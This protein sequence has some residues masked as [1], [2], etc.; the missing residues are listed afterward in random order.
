MSVNESASRRDGEAARTSD[1]LVARRGIARVVPAR[2]AALPT[3]R[4][5]GF[6]LLALV[7]VFGLSAC[8]LGIDESPYSSI[9]P[10]TETASDIQ[11]LYKTLFYM[12]AV[13]FVLVQFLVLYTALRY[14][15]K[16]R[17]VSRPA[18]VH[19]NSRLEITWT[20]IPAVV[21]LIILVPTISILYS[22]DAD[23]ED[24]ENAMIVQVY[25]KQ[26]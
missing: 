1:Q 10:A 13:V 4:L 9:D 5:C 14:R 22:M 25:G 15:R 19:G 23:A 18:Q 24:E 8:S 2:L 3:S 12:A 6:A 21:L 16:K 17:S 26:W 11:G 20:V 7:L